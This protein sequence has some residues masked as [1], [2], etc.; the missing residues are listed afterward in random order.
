MKTQLYK[1]R[2]LVTNTTHFNNKGQNFPLEKDEKTNWMDE[3]PRI[4][5]KILSDIH[6]LVMSKKNDDLVKRHLQLAQRECIALLDMLTEAYVHQQT[7]QAL[8]HATADCLET[9]LL[10][11][12]NQHQYYFNWDFY[13][14]ALQLASKQKEL[15]KNINLL[16]AGLRN[17]KVNR[18]LEELI[19]A[20]FNRVYHSSFVTYQQLNYIQAL[21]N[22]LIKLCN[23]VG[24]LKFDELL[25]EHLFYHGF[26]ENAFVSYCKNHIT[27]TIAQLYQADIQYEKLCFYEKVLMAQQE[28][29]N[30]SFSTHRLSIK[31]QM[32]AFV[33]AELNYILK[34]QGYKANGNSVTSL[35]FKP[36]LPVRIKASISADS[37]AYFIRL[38]VETEVIIH[39]PRTQLL[40]VMARHVQT[41]GI[42]DK[43]L[44]AQSL[45]T[46][47]KQVTQSTAIKVKTLLHSML[48]KLEKDFG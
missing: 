15:S 21:Q 41:P 25:V 37:L 38:L 22:S 24:N 16:K 48:K 23:K 5:E 34:K 45:G 33:T 28:K 18:E 4:R 9:I 32:L 19:I 2:K 12:F 20:A 46:K 7:D 29:P 17:K 11:M 36:P 43:L 8:R 6:L 14:P 27:V 35:S 40:E 3:L 42:G 44:S 1:L 13:V 10:H 26:N 31:T 47:Y 30:C 39:Q